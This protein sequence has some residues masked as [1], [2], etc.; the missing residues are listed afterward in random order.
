MGT[1]ADVGKPARY[2]PAPPNGKL[3]ENDARSREVVAQMQADEHRHAEVAVEAGAAELP[4][5]KEL[6]RLASRVMTTTAHWI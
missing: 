1:P 5:V 2:D 6:M 3:P 4:P